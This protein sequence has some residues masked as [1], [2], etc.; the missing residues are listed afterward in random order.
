MSEQIAKL[1]KNTLSIQ[2]IVTALAAIMV[3]VSPVY[4][5]ITAKMNENLKDKI[6]AA[7]N[8]TAVTK[9]QFQDYVDDQA[10]YQI[11]ANQVYKNY[12][13]KID[14]T[15]L[16]IVP[17]IVKNQS[18]TMD[19]MDQMDTRYAVVGKSEDDK[20]SILLESFVAIGT[21]HEQEARHQEIVRYLKEIQE[22]QLPVFLPSNPAAIKKGIRIE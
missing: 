5:L 14:S 10:K 22:K 11:A 21:R 2:T 17:E 1:E 12:F 3:V 7:I 13:F 20:Y 19:R 18:V 16:L 6:V 8:E 15:L 9:Q 4:Y